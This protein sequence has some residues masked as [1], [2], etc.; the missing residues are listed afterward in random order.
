MTKENSE[1]VEFNLNLADKQSHNELALS[2]HLEN[3]VRHIA[4]QLAEQI[5]KSDPDRFSR[6]SND[7]RW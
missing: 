2:L 3:L 6:S 4:Q 1:T 7:E 5:F